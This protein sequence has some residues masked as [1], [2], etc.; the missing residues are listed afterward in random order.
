[1]LYI[2]DKNS[3]TVRSQIFIKVWDS[4]NC[5]RSVQNPNFDVPYFRTEHPSNITHKGN[6]IVPSISQ[7]KVIESPYCEKKNLLSNESLS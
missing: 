3:F 2:I 1:M 7:E 4:Y 5:K 6:N